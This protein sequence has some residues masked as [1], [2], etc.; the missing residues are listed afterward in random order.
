MNSYTPTPRVRARTL[1][2]ASQLT[3]LQLSRELFCLYPFSP[4]L[5]FALQSLCFP[6]KSGPHPA[7]PCFPGSE[8]TACHLFLQRCRQLWP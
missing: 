1:G 8:H 4:G 7:Q 6:L 3:R 5:G 2:F